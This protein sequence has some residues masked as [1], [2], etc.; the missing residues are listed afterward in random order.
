M[1]LKLMIGLCHDTNYKIRMDGVLFLK[2][3]LLKE[4]ITSC[5]RF[6]SLYVPELMEMLNDEEAY[7]R[8]EAI[9]VA[10]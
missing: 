10:T 4:G 2:E 5:P 7:I 9:E 6:S 3:Y 8:I 1:I